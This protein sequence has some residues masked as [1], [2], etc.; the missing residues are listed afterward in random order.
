LKIFVSWS[1]ER[2]QTLAHALRDWL[3]LVLHYAEPWLSEADV[4]AG[5]RWASVIA[6]ELEATNFGI[7]CVTPENAAS[8]WLLFEA[9]AL[10]KSMQGAR[11][12]PL[13]F[14]LEFSDITGP[15]AQF[16]A[17]KVDKTGLSEVIQSINQGPDQCIAEERAKQLFAAL[18]PEFE[19]RLA[20]LPTQ[21]PTEKHMRPQHEIIEE[22]VA[23]VRGLDSRFRDVETAVS[24][25]DIRPRRR[26]RPFHPM[27]MDELMGGISD[28][29]SDP[30]GILMLAGMLRTDM[31][32]LAEVMVE[33]YREIRSGDEK[34]ATRAV[35]RLRRL[36]RQVGRGRFIDEMLMGGSKDAHIMVMEL[37]HMIERFLHL[38]EEARSELGAGDVG[39]GPS[40]PA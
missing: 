10:A 39:D 3:P 34:T 33:T 22:L 1:G 23:G 15:L 2:S 19:Q 40:D 24:D 21:A 4:A 6:K 38:H 31:P 26:L 25:P 27:M 29:P 14:N 35:H 11:V 9:G 28:D 13:L 32:W 7:I 12:I 30:V 37:P 16:Q 18:W 17:K 36:T 5:D 20:S 8:P